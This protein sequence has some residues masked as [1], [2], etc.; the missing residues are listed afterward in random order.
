MSHA[1]DL[2][3]VSIDEALI[4]VTTAVSR[5]RSAAASAGSPHD[6]AKDFA[7][8]IRAEVKEATGCES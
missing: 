1:D 7:E 5:L 3:A 8:S 2:E 4:D 6:P